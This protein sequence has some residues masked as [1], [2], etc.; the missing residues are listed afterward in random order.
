MDLAAQNDYMPLEIMTD[1]AKRSYF[2]HSFISL[3]GYHTACVCGE[4]RRPPR[5]PWVPGGVMPSECP[6]WHMRNVGT[7]DQ[8]EAKQR[9]M[10]RQQRDC[11]SLSP[12][13]NPSGRSGS[14]PSA[15]PTGWTPTLFPP[16]SLA[17]G[18]LHCAP[19]NVKFGEAPQTQYLVQSST[20]QVQCQ[21]M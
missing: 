16:A 6:G 3:W 18:G 1:C 8:S 5:P 9:V 13:V 14:L 19:T 4:A 20:Q 12:L 11:V 17:G 2:M 10:T 7:G 21:R 15:V